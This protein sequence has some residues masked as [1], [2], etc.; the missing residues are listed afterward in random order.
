MEDMLHAFLTPVLDGDALLASRPVCFTSKKKI[1]VHWLR[2]WVGLIAGL[3]VAGIPRLLLV[4][5][6][7]WTSEIFKKS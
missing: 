2:D 4:I 3:D 5:S 7:F 1:T 6:L